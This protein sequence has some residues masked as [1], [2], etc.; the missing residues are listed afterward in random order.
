MEYIEDRNIVKLK[1]NQ[2]FIFNFSLDIRKKLQ[3]F[4]IYDKVF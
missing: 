1:A 3:K 2:T 4:N